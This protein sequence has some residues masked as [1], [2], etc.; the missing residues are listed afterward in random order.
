MS[1][2]NIRNGFDKIKEKGEEYFNL[3]KQRSEIQRDVEGLKNK[4]KEEG[5]NRGA[6]SDR[7]KKLVSIQ[8]QMISIRKDI[9]KINQQIDQEVRKEIQDAV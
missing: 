9:E 7:N 5:T 3:E 2:K 8:N 1:L 4:Y 6:F